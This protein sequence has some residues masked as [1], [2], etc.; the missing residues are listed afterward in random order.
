V[1]ILNAGCAVAMATSPPLSVPLVPT[2]ITKGYKCVVIVDIEAVNVQV[3]YYHHITDVCGSSKY[4]A[5]GIIILKIFTRINARSSIL[6]KEV[7][8]NY[9]ISY[10]INISHKFFRFYITSRTN[11]VT[12]LTL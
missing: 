11:D 12:L 10:I 1:A 5:K 9:R 3:K 8:K 2:A 4:L 7:S 6:T